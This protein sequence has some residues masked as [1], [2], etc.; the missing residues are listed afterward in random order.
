M[1]VTGATHAVNAAC[2]RYPFPAA[3][4]ARSLRECEQTVHDKRQQSDHGQQVL[5]LGGLE[6]APS[7]PHQRADARQRR[8]HLDLSPA[9]CISLKTSGLNVRPPPA[10]GCALR[11]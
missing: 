10:V 6:V 9:F 3:A 1:Q 8:E 7:L 5:D 11:L 4:A 2:R